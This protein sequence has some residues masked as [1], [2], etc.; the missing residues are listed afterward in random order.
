L[1]SITFFFFFSENH[2]VYEIMWEKCGTTGQVTADNMAHAHCMPGTERYKH[3]L[4]ICNTYRFSVGAVVA[5]TQLNIK[6]YVI[7]GGPR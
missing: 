7:A 5:L 6:L 4:R 3:T 1:H 2:A